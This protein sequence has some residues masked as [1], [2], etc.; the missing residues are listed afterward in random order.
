M[1]DGADVLPA[2]ADV[3]KA[4]GATRRCHAINLLEEFD[5]TPIQASKL[6]DHITAIE[7]GISPSRASGGPYR[8]V[9]NALCQTHLPALADVGV[10]RYDSDRK[11][12]TTGPRYPVVQLLLSLNCTAYT[13]LQGNSGWSSPHQSPIEQGD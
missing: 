2:L 4:L 9:Y 1:A 6:A 13:I 11:T 3:H 10:I 12:L 8:N 5:D 7:E